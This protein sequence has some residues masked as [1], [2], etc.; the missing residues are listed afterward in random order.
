MSNIALGTPVRLLPPAKYKINYYSFGISAE[1][2]IKVKDIDIK[3]WLT[4]DFV[5]LETGDLI[6][7]T[8]YKIESFW[9]KQGIEF[10][11]IQHMKFS[12]LDS[13]GIFFRN[14]KVGIYDVDGEGIFDQKS[15]ILFPDGYWA[16]PTK[17]V[18]ETQIDR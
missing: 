5:A 10:R 14:I 3:N 9:D 4:V 16:S 7:W 8:K 6:S 13:S 17:F 15:L 1:T 2:F 12:I 11:N 18:H